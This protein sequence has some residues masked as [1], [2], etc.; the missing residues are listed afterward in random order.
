[1]LENSNNP[2]IQSKL[3]HILEETNGPRKPLI[4]ETVDGN[5]RGNLPT[6]GLKSRIESSLWGFAQHGLSKTKA[7]KRFTSFFDLN[8]L[9][10]K[11]FAQSDDEIMLPESPEQEI[12]PDGEILQL[13]IDPSLPP[14]LIHAQVLDEL[15]SDGSSMLTFGDSHEFAQTTEITQTTQTSIENL[16]QVSEYTPF[17]WDDDD[18]LMSDRTFMDE[19][20]ATD[21]DFEDMDLG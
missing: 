12:D 18:I 8:G 20:F 9:P 13:D 11:P 10:R 4:P 3:S 21:E 16:S 17:T 1:M 19:R 6:K 14:N 7:C 5:T 15:L 2:V